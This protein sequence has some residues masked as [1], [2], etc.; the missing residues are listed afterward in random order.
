MSILPDSV[1]DVQALA[2]AYLILTATS[3]G[4]RHLFRERAACERL[5]AQYRSRPDV[6]LALAQR[7]RDWLV[8]LFQHLGERDL[9]DL[10]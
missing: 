7:D 4:V 8:A 5:L 1:V 3:F 10:E 9:E 6:G 2:R